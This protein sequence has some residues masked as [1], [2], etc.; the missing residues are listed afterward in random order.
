[1][2]VLAD[3]NGLKYA[4]VT[5]ARKDGNIVWKY[6]ASPQKPAPYLGTLYFIAVVIYWS[7]SI[8]HLMEPSPMTWSSSS[9][10]CHSTLT[11]CL[12]F[13]NQWLVASNSLKSE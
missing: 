2:R 1:M 12:L 3:D 5:N 10:L 8:K 6:F 7:A 11:D 9:L 4:A 13:P